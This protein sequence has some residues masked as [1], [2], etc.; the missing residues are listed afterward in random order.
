MSHPGVCG[1]SLQL[2]E[3]AE[4]IGRVG[5]PLPGDP[6]QMHRVEA[7]VGRCELLG[8]VKFVQEKPGGV[9]VHLH[10]VEENPAE[11]RKGG[12]AGLSRERRES[13][14]CSPG[15][16]AYWVIWGRT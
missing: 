13:G 15:D 6:S 16:T 4:H 5:V 10:Q 12:W 9:R 1:G 2:L 14:W 7:G 8:A 11:R 3:Q